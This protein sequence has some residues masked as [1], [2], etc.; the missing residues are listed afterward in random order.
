MKSELRP[1]L[2]LV[3]DIDIVLDYL[4][5]YRVDAPH[6]LRHPKTTN[7]LVVCRVDYFKG[8]LHVMR[9][10]STY[11]DLAVSVADPDC[12]AK[13]IDLVLKIVEVDRPQ[14]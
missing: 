1:Q 8:D 13:I 11:N 2:E 10:W 12:F 3:L 4:D 7:K 6:T 5:I 9:P 14:W